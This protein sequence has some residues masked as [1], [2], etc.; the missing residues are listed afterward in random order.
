MA[1]TSTKSGQPMKCR[2]GGVCPQGYICKPTSAGVHIC[3]SASVVIDDEEDEEEEEP[4]AQEIPIPTSTVK[5]IRAQCAN[6]AVESAAK[7]APTQ[8]D[9][10]RPDSCPAGYE[11]EVA[12]NVDVYICCKASSKILSFKKTNFM[13]L[14][15]GNVC[16][17]QT[18]PY[19][20]PVSKK[21]QSCVAGAHDRC[22]NGYRCSY[23]NFYEKYYCCSTGMTR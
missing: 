8:C 11:C 5:P 22:P 3:C 21:A 9:S 16:N 20:N 12:S 10:D 19:V 1:Y 15:S 17:G 14:F 7:K 6:E 2:Q 4:E 13:Q 18:I 23:S